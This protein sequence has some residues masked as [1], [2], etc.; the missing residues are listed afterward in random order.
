MMIDVRNA[1]TGEMEFKE[2][3]LNAEMKGRMFYTP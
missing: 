1:E 3:I 2:L